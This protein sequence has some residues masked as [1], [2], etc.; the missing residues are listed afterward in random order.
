[1]GGSVSGDMG[2]LKYLLNPMPARELFR[3]HL[4]GFDHSNSLFRW[5]VLSRRCRDAV[6]N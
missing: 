5:M 3:Q 6:L 2:E 1:M 4:A